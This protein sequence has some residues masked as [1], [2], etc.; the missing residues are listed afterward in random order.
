MRM[1]LEP[2][3]PLLFRTGRSFDA[4]ESSFADTL[5][6]PTPETLQGAV[7]A[8]IATHWDTSKTLEEVFLEQELINLIGSR[9]FGYGR[10][11]ITGLALGKR[12]DDKTIERLFRPPAH[13]L[14]IK[15][16]QSNEQHLMLL[17]PRQRK[18]VISDLGRGANYLVP[19]YE[20]EIEREP[21]ENWLTESGLEKVL[22]ND[23][24]LSKDEIVPEKDIF[25]RE[26]RLGIGMD[27]AT[28]TIRE[29]FLYQTQVIR[30]QPDFGFVVDIRLSKSNISPD[31]PYRESFMDDTQT[32]Q[33]LKLPQHGWIMLG[34]ERR[35]ARFEIFPSLAS[36][37]EQVKLGRLLYLAT[38]AAFDSGWQ[39][40]PSFA[41]PLAAAINRYQSI[42]G[43]E[44]NP[45]N[46]GGTNKIMRR[47]VPAGSIYF[48][49]EPVSA[50]QPLTGYGMEIGYGII[51]TGEWKQ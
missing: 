31:L 27:N 17:K 36:S 6:P 21:F 26:S 9:G 50:T 19:E 1:F 40:L 37:L 44:L 28:K 23:T 46:S 42:G 48:F 20:G 51:Y 8:A 22:H 11:R 33:E 24:R 2:T 45:S 41:S 43:W 10:F 3:E 30:M 35:T 39:P 34:G 7:R 38:P 16:A 4:G 25:R 12:K 29:G 15:D 18:G 13:L 5:F 32:Q 14:I 47:C 49:E